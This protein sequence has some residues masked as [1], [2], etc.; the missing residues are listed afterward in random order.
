RDLLSHLPQ[1]AGGTLPVAPPLG[2]APGDPA[3]PGPT[4]P[5]AGYDILDVARRPPAAGALLELAP[6][7][8]RNLVVGFARLEGRPVGFV[9]NQPRPLGGIL[10]AEASEKGAWFVNVCD[11]FGVGLVVLVDTP[12][13]LPGSSQERAGVIR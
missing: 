9:A 4:D 1:H 2:A 10:D 12:G 8:A 7:W 5:R 3:G 13:F 6:R 11:R